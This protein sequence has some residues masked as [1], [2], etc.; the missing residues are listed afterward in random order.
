M[1]IYVMTDLEG[2]AGVIDSDNW[3][4]CDG[5]YYETAKSLLTEEVNAAVRGFLDGGAAEI[6]VADGHGPGAINASL[7]DPRVMLMRGWPVGFPLELDASYDAVAWIGQHAKAGTEYAHLAHTQNFGMLDY[8]INGISV[9]E[10]GEFAFCAIELGVKPI[11]GSGDMAFTEEAEALFPGIETVAVK[12]GTTPGKGEECTAE[13]YR[14]RN[15]AAVHFSP[16]K[17]RRMIYEGALRAVTGKREIGLPKLQPP[18]V[19]EAKWRP[20]ADKPARELTVE[21][22]SSIA[23]AVNLSLGIKGPK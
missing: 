10:F 2:V 12:Y 23:Q 15:K 20:S 21:H 19:V 11:F 7:L 6:V 1:K 18:Y 9:G 22:P 3:C 5:R 14:L 8:S 17:A 13:E 16:D 4:S